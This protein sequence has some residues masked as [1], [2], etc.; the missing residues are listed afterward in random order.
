[1]RRDCAADG[2]IPTLRKDCRNLR[3]DLVF[4]RLSLWIGRDD[5]VVTG[6]R[7]L[8]FVDGLRR[9][10][11][12]QLHHKAVA[13]LATIRGNGRVWSVAP[14]IIRSA[15]V[16]PLLLDVTNHQIRFGIERDVA[17]DRVLTSVDRL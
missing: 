3:S 12:R 2:S 4:E 13:W 16:R 17:A 1:E 7:E 15:Q 9:N 5:D 14:E 10:R 8:K 11:I 6:G